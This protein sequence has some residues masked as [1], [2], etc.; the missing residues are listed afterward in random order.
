M[1]NYIPKIIL[2]DI[3]ISEEQCMGDSLTTINQAFIT[4]ADGINKL[5]GLFGSVITCG[6]GVN[7]LSA[8]GDFLLINVNGI[9]RKIRLWD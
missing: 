4:L 7:A 9:P 5:D 3:P 8:T 1:A 6:T 2:T